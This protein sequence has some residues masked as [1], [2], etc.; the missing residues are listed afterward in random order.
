MAYGFERSMEK[1][2][3]IEQRVPQER[4]G[5]GDSVITTEAYNVRPALFI[6]RDEVSYAG[7]KRTADQRFDLGHGTLR[8]ASTLRRCALS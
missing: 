7:F 4:V 1:R 3:T 6:T 2:M 8:I 5:G